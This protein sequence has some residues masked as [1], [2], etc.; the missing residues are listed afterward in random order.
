VS[1]G[2]R[3]IVRLLHFGAPDVVQLL[4]AAGE[5]S[6]LVKGLGDA[7]GPSATLQVFEGRSGGWARHV[8]ALTSVEETIGAPVDVVVTAA[9]A[10]LADPSEDALGSLVALTRF[11]KEGGRH[12]IALN[13]STVG[14]DRTASA[15]GESLDLR[16][17]RTNLAL[18]VASH[19][20][21]L[22]ILDVDRLIAE[23]PLPDKVIAPF[24]Y[25]PPVVEV[26]RSEATRILSELGVP[27]GRT[28]MELRVPFIRQATHL[29]L[30]RWFKDEG[31][32]VAPEDVL[33][34]LRL[35]GIQR[36]S[37]PSNAIVLASIKGHLPLLRRMFNRER[38]RH[39]DKE[40]RISVVASDTGVLRAIAHGAGASIQ[41][42][43][44]LA[45]LTIDPGAPVSTDGVPSLFRAVARLEEST[46]EV[47]L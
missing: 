5:A 30:E 35:L 7:A 43:D 29:V 24:E 32:A 17:R 39:R 8:D 9:S 27:G 2:D 46:T 44:R 25:S 36:L 4:G 13:A 18:V 20:T 16:I 41:A 33:C 21:G 1:D 14:P 42:S 45:L 47:G 11:A 22:A 31:D 34:E 28:V 10:E 3:R 38:L 6:T 15:N 23:T 19:E 40:A 26:L 12:V 37:R